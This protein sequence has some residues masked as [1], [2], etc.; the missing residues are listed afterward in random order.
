LSL[1]NCWPCAEARGAA[2][3]LCP[4]IT[5]GPWDWTAGLWWWDP[6]WTAG[7]GA[8]PC[9]PL[10]WATVGTWESRDTYDRNGKKLTSV[11]QVG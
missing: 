2:V 3:W 7:L 4:D 8:C 10:F 6:P 9:P 11:Y 1:W 5:E